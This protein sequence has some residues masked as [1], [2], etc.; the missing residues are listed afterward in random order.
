M[1]FFNKKRHKKISNVNPHSSFLIP[2]C[3]PGGA[4]ISALFITAIVAILATAL[5]VEQRLLIHEGNLLL[6]ADQSYLNLQYVQLKGEDLVKKYAHQFLI[7]TNPSVNLNPL[8]DKITLKQL[9]KMTVSGEIDDEQ[10]KFNLNDLV[11]MQNQQRFVALLRGVMT[12]SKE[13]AYDIAKSITAFMMTGNDNAYYL[14][15]N[16]PYQSSKQEMANVTELRLIKGVSAEIYQK[17][18]PYVTALPIT[19]PAAITPI[20]APASQVPASMTTKINVNSAKKYVFLAADPALHSSQLNGL[21]A[22]EKQGPFSQLALFLN[23]AKE[24]QIPIASNALTTQSHY[25]FVHAKAEYD[26]Q[27]SNLDSLLVTQRDKNNKLNVNLVWQD[28]Y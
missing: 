2:H 7:L 25:F 23:C 5:A 26:H 17:L 1:S 8:E 22:C 12:I 6:N 28:F 4:L 20:Q 21:M 13:K 27:L 11:Y 10:G 18:K 9:G 14:K 24:A 16:P 19:K 3:S 15:L